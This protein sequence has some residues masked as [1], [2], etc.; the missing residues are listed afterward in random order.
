[1]DN[2]Y[3]I[4]YI[5][6]LDYKIIS[7]SPPSTFNVVCP[8][9][10]KEVIDPCSMAYPEYMNPT[11]QIANRISI[12][13]YL[14]KTIYN[15]YYYAKIIFC[16]ECKTKFSFRVTDILEENKPKNIL[17]RLFYNPPETEVSD[18]YLSSNKLWR[19]DIC[20]KI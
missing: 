5:D 6:D 10:H 20:E 7:I 12:N 11:Q 13:N 8:I 2:M 14:V 3:N 4:D 19:T 15:Y 9:C 17:K 16:N 18:E 1:M